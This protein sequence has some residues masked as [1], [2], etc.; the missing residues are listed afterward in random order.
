MVIKINCQKKYR[1]EKDPWGT[2]RARGVFYRRIFEILKKYAEKNRIHNVLD[3]GCGKGAFT[4]ELLKLGE[5]ITGIEISPLAVNYAKNKYPKIRFIEGNIAKLDQLK[6]ENNIFDIVTVLD[7]LYYFPIQVIRKILI[8]IWDLMTED[9]ILVLRHWSPGGGY[10]TY[11][12]WLKL[13]QEKYKI[14]YSEFLEETGHS[15]LVCQKKFTKII[16]TFDY[17]TWQPLPKGK[18]INWEKDI[19][20]P[21]EQLLSLA[22][23]YKIKLS[24]FV[25]MGEYYWCQVNESLVAQKM[26][27]QWQ[28]IIEKG[29]DVQMHLHPAWLPEYGAKYDEKNKKWYWNKQYQSLHSLAYQD[30]E[31]ILKQCKFNLEKILKPIDPKYQAIVFRAGAYQVQPNKEIFEIFKNIKILADSS[32]W[33]GGFNRE[34]KLDFRMAYS[35]HQPYFSNKYNINYLAPWGEVEVLEIPIASNT[36]ERFLLDGFC[37][38]KGIKFIE[39]ILKSPKK[40]YLRY[41]L[42]QYPPNFS[43]KRNYLNKIYSFLIKLLNKIENILINTEP[44]I[45]NNKDNVIVG[46][47]HTK[48]LTDFSLIELEKFFKY[49]TARKDYK[50]EKISNIALEFYN[51]KKEIIYS[52]HIKQQ[53][54]YDKHAVLGK[55]RNDQQSFYAQDKIPLDRKKILD[56]GCEAGYWTKRINDKVAKTIGVDISKE[57]LIKA[58]ERYPEIKFHQMD[59]HELGFPDQYFDCIYADN[60]LEHSPFPRKVLNEIYR[61]LTDKGLLIAL[62]PPDARNPKFSGLDHVWKT[63]KDE[64]EKRLKEIGF[65]NI[66]IEDINIVKKF[67]MAPYKASN[68]SMLFITAW[69]WKNGYNNLERCK[70]LMNFVYISLSPEKSQVSNNALDILKGG[71]ALCAGYVAVMKF[72]CEREGFKT[73]HYTLYAQNHPKGRGKNKIDTHEIL[74]IYIN[75]KWQ[76]FDPTVNLFLNHGVKEVLRNPDLVDKNIKNQKKDKRYYERQYRLYCSSWFYKNMI[77]YKLH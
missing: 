5:N 66:K 42:L 43:R 12:E 53:I 32:V 73:R 26:E 25:D 49:C 47:G 77:K 1:D 60:T 8:A 21:T 17:E 33:K 19:F 34:R 70:D 9:G 24:F 64:I 71:Y 55:N 10:L 4:N 36:K 6:L 54:K 56:L 52:D 31:K 76:I 16:L 65:S 18:E 28:E 30:I 69:K 20:I 41:R 35:N 40:I 29:H 15:I 37:Y 3:L 59:F 51:N 63:D 39:S 14:I 50:T 68:N 61:I 72:L 58:K 62:I 48:L 38:K 75:N 45:F 13:V 44:Y 2:G 67:R 22:D 27:N 57:F 7:V 23:E 46:I 74:E 11:N